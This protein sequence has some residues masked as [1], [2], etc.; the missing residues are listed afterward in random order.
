[1]FCPK[2]LV[3]YWVSGFLVVA[4]CIAC[5]LDNLNMTDNSSSIVSAPARY[6]DLAWA[7]GKV[8]NVNIGYGD[9][10]DV[11]D[12]SEDIALSA[13]SVGNAGKKKG[14]E[15]A[16]AVASKRKKVSSFFAPRTTPGS[17][18]SIKSAMA[19]K[20]MVDNAKLAVARWWYDANVPFNGAHSKYYQPMFDAAL[21][22]GLGF[23]APSFHD[24]RGNLLR[25][26]VDEIST[27]LDKFRPIWDLYGCSVMSDGWSNRRQELAINCLV[28]CPKGTMF[29]KSIDASGLTKDADTLYG[30]FNEVVQLISPNYIVQF[31]TDNEAAYKAAGK[32]LQREYVF[33]WA[34]CAAH[35]IDLMLE[36]LADVG[37]FP[38]ID[39]TIIKAK[40]ITKFIYNHGFVVNMMRKEF[41]NGRELC[42]PEI[43]RFATN[44]L[45]L[46]C[47]LKFKKELR[48][49]FTCDKWL[50]SKL[51]KSVV[52]KEVAKLV[53]EDRD[54]QLECQHVVKLSEPLL[55]V[56]RLTDGDGKP[57]MGYLY[58]AIDK[59]KET[60]KSNLK[61]R[62]SFYMPVLRVI[63]A[64]WDKQLSSP[65]YSA[66]CFLNP[67]IFFKPSFK[68]Q[69][70][71]TR[72]LLSTITA[73]VTDDYMQD[74][75]SSQLEEYKQ[76]TGDFGMPIAVCQREKL[77]PE[78][79]DPVSL[80]NIDVLADWV[81][82][83]EF[84]ITQEDLDN[85]GGWDV[86][87]PEPA[88][89]NLEDEEVHYEDEEDALHDIHSQ[90]DWE[91]GGEGDPYH[92]IE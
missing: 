55:R 64:R 52:G 15:V 8:L 20:E 41:S 19:T 49:M 61:N 56:L 66:G 30:I 83:E 31:I 69:K 18:P 91:F 68:K 26:L 86:L 6:D 37:H 14:K 46:Q 88:A 84:V 57:S 39:A 36:N 22:V 70:E 13:D 43:T 10:V 85:D 28:Y 17:Q 76:A 78:A 16:V 3:L 71:F 7:H 92:Y 38:T 42:R 51:A 54:F 90:Y 72:G 5:L 45:S 58:E 62:L 65:L 35:C 60:I 75:I 24:L 47:L 32:M 34:P 80:D 73:L 27:Y 21:V 50:N 1:M 4:Y 67:R 23:K 33:F 11:D 89:V 2:M 74:L 25:T 82:E 63:D 79:L 9:C 44:Y 29:F 59:P 53:L 87:Q 40:N 48:Q 77:N 12:D 81:S